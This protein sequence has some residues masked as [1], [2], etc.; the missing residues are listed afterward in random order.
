VTLPIHETLTVPTSGWE[1]AQVIRGTLTVPTSGWERA[2]VF[3]GCKV[4]GGGWGELA[5][6]VPA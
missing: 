5:A 2:Q 4:T 6:W 1:R 3:W